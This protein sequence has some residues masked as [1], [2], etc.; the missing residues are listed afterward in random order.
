[1]FARGGGRQPTGCA[2]TPPLT[3]RRANSQDNNEASWALQD[4]A[5]APNVIT[6]RFSTRGV[7]VQFDVQGGENVFT[8]RKG[9]NTH[10]GDTF[11]TMDMVLW[12]IKPNHANRHQSSSLPKK[13]GMGKGQFLL[14]GINVGPGG[15]KQCRGDPCTTP[16]YDPTSFFEMIRKEGCLL[17]PNEILQLVVMHLETITETGEAESWQLVSSWCVLALQRRAKTVSP[18][19]SEQLRRG[20]TNI[21]AIISVNTFQ[22]TPPQK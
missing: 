20:T 6:G 16:T 7:N 18:S 21:S 19:P 11:C 2:D 4:D 9:G 14:T 8:L 12:V 22:R 17:V 3:A 13:M 15:R 1:M 5:L 10:R